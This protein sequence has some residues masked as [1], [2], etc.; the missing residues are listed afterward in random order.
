MDI[1]FKDKKLR[2]LCEVRALAERKLGPDCARK[3]RSRLSDLEAA[4]C[5]TDLQTGRP[6]ALT[7]DRTGQFAL[8]LAAGRRLVFAPAQ[9][10]S[11]HH[12]DGGVDWSRVHAV[13]IE[14][15][16]DYHD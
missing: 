15:I 6:H 12:A 11:P 9:D 14:F 3:L 2:G 16:G 13:R 1:H 10:A 7:G 8:N 5:V 4:A